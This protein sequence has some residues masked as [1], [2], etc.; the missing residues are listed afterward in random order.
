ME[1]AQVLALLR[2]FLERKHLVK[3]AAT[4]SQELRTLCSLST[5][6]LS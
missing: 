1:D 6:V 2:D 4:L 3:T 5:A